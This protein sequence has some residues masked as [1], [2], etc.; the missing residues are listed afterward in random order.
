MLRTLP[1]WLALAF[2]AL[3]VPALDED[4][5]VGPPLSGSSDF[6]GWYDDFLRP[7]GPIGG[8]WTPANG[9]WQV[10][11]GRGAHTSGGAD[12]ILRH[13]V[14]MTELT[15]TS[16]DV[17]AIANG[18]AN[19]A[20]GI[21]L[22]IGGTDALLFRVEDL[23]P[24]TVGFTNWSILH[25]TSLTTWGPWAGG[26][27]ASSGAFATPVPKLRLRG[28]CV[29]ADTALL[30]VDTDLDGFSDLVNSRTNLSSISANFGSGVALLASGSAARF[31]DF[32][33][34]DQTTVL[35][36]GTP[37]CQSSSLSFDVPPLP[38][39]T[40][41]KSAPAIIA[42]GIASIEVIGS[43]SL[44][45][46]TI[47][48][49]NNA[50]G[51]CLTVAG[52]SG[53][54][55]VADV[56]SPAGSPAAGAGLDFHLNVPA[57]AFG[58]SLVDQSG[59]GCTISLL[60][61]ELGVATRNFTYGS[62]AFPI[63]PVYIGASDNTVFDRVRL[64]FPAGSGGLAIDNL[65]IDGCHTTTFSGGAIGLGN[66]G[67]FPT[68][69]ATPLDIPFVLPTAARNIDRVEFDGLSHTALGQLQ[70]V[71]F[72][73]FGNG[74]NLFYR[75]GF[76]GTNTGSTGDFVSAS[77][78]VVENGGISFPTVGNIGG[79][80]FN[81]SPGVWPDG[82]SGIF[83]TDL[84]NIP[85]VPGGTYRLRIYDWAAGNFG[86]VDE[87]TVR[88]TAGSMA[89]PAVYCT[90]TTTSGGCLP[91]I[92]CNFAPS[93]SGTPPVEILVT[94]LERDRAGI[95]FYGTEPQQIPW[96][97]NGTNFLCVKSPSQR[98]PTQISAGG[99]GC[100]A[101]ML[102]DL[103]AFFNATPTA[104]GLP[105]LPGDT[106]YAQAWFRDPPACKTT[107]LTQGLILVMQP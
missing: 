49:A 47:G 55:A 23:D 86:S 53:A 44:T 85:I 36:N 24:N 31:D 32:G 37:D 65:W 92:K 64:T 95:L 106:F 58:F 98:L 48:A 76:N 89:R 100:N 3:P 15:L 94:G 67:S 28:Q 51:R 77:V 74:H 56:G 105:L 83:N 39:G 57:R 5:D 84:S 63:A 43:W 8:L 73:P 2:L 40:I 27:G 16:I 50:T 93:I 9:I 4:D 35:A 70:A 52:G 12:E 87:I 99:P 72:D 45:G 75:V 46:D 19:Q 80:T 54:L 42:G 14:S 21:V 41:A 10:I 62:G 1:R 59:V 66:P 107:G 82:T 13:A 71:I 25:R 101:S 20:I 90:T 22:G 69:P 78:T 17:T 91:E 7:D 26:T 34:R 29:N 61:G 60:N 68:L 38:L 102:F 18:S 33:F 79:G 30:Q 88:G 11:G 97:A 96:C 103:T 81:Q 6:L 104:L